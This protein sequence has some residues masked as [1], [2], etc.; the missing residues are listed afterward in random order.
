MEGQPIPS[1]PQVPYSC[2]PATEES[3]CDIL[4]GTDDADSI[5]RDSSQAPLH[6][7]PS[8]M[9]PASSVSPDTSIHLTSTQ[10]KS[11]SPKPLDDHHTMEDNPQEDSQ[12]QYDNA[13][14]CG[15]EQQGTAR[16][17][18]PSVEDV[19]GDAW[20]KSE[21]QDSPSTYEKPHY[22]GQGPS[23]FMNPDQEENL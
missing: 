1:E 23:E 16:G 11:D 12:W 6:F 5:T 13:K 21:R 14:S 22:G 3:A 8:S 7:P 15:V 17:E 9:D 20:M 19:D 18:D 4:P 2:P 10:P